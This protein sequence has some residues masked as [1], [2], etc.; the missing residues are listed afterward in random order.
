MAKVKILLCKKIVIEEGVAEGWQHIANVLAS[1][2]N[3]EVK[4]GKEPEEDG[5]NI[6]FRDFADKCSRFKG[7]EKSLSGYVIQELPDGGIIIT[8]SDKFSICHAALYLIDLFKYKLLTDDKLISISNT[9]TFERLDIAFDD[10]TAGFCRNADNFDLETHVRDLARTGV[11]SLEVNQLYDDV[12]IQVRERLVWRDKYQWWAFYMPAL[13]MFFESDLSRGT[14]CRSLLERNK[15]QMRRATE[16]ARN[17]G[18]KPIFVTFEPRAWPERLFAK[19][20]ELRGARVDMPTY[21]AE[22]EYAPDVNHPLVIE[23]YRELT[24]KLLGEIPDLDLI[25]VWSQDSCAGFPWSK[26]LYTGENGPVKFRKRPPEEGVI[27]F[28]TTLRDAGRKINPDLRLNI[29]LCWFPEDEQDALMEKLPRDISVATTIFPQDLYKNFTPGIVDDNYNVQR[30]KRNWNAL[31]RSKKFNRELTVQFEDV[32]NPWKPLGPLQGFPYPYATCEMLNDVVNHEVKKFVIR[33]GLTS[34]VFVPHFINNE[35]IRSF[36]YQEGTFD[37]ENL[38]CSRAKAW[39]NSDEEA[40]LLLH[41]WKGCDEIFRIYNSPYWTVSMFVSARTLFRRLIRPMVPNPESL[42][43]P[44]TRF[45]RPMEF[46]V[47]ESDPAWN[48]CFSYGYGQIFSDEEAV[49]RIKLCDLLISKAQKIKD[50]LNG[51][52][53]AFADALSDLEFR[54]NG[55]MRM[56]GTDRS[57]FAIQAAIHACQNSKS[58]T[59]LASARQTLKDEMSREIANSKEFIKLLQET[60]DKKTLIP[61]SS[62]EDNIYLLRAPLSHQLKLKVKVMAAHLDDKVGIN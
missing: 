28:M 11:Q 43:L 38:L 51:A 7:T 12:P 14:Y 16:A 20:P 61:V 3:L 29:N 53:L 32:S 26:R 6:G 13:D 54:I 34:Q 15:L 40:S 8:G 21:S 62:G 25:E 42:E 44:E 24:T 35:V 1:E 60:E 30:I 5:L 58:E 17:Y 9:A 2:F 45:Y 19:Y 41:A 46:L 39:S 50:K 37:L 18:I 23:H 59:E 56:T 36:Q 55:F 52:G 49:E 57:I 33:G 48:D 27:N 31:D 10:Y 4:S 22:A 47:G